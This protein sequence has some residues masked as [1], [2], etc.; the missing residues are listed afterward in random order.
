MAVGGRRLRT[1]RCAVART[2]Y[3]GIYLAIVRSIRIIDRLQHLLRIF[4]ARHRVYPLIRTTVIFKIAPVRNLAVEQDSLHILR[5]G[6]SEDVDR[7]DKAGNGIT[8]DENDLL[9][10]D[11]RLIARVGEEDDSR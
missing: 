5:C 2:V 1:G 9:G 7:C 6:L 8:G 3:R 10:L 11:V 4:R